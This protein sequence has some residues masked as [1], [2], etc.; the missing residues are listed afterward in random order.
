MKYNIAF[1]IYIAIK[2]A[3]LKVCIVRKE[4][5]NQNDAK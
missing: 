5:V 3:A 1:G 2:I 4:H